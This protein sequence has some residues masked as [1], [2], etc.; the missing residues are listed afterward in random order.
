MSIPKPGQQAPDFKL[1]DSNSNLISL[2]DFK[3]KK[4]ILYFYPKDNTP[5]CTIEACEFRD[6]YN[7]F[8]DKGAIILGISAD[9]QESHKKFSDKLSLPF[10]LLADID[11]ETSKKY[12]V[13]EEKSFLGRKYYGIN[14]TTFLIDEHG[15][16]IKVFEKVKPGSHAKEIL[17]LL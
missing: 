6:G 2:K 3:G 9:N 14:R 11:A 17:S 5:G 12:G 13:Y 10:P 8:K 4:V 16:I 1:K 15:K 7:L